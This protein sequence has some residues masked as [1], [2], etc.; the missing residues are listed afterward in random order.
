MAM[1]ARMKVIPGSRKMYIYIL[2]AP[3]SKLST[4]KLTLSSQYSI[5]PERDQ[6]NTGL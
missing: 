4:S 2:K 1:V 5:T 3:A 6:L